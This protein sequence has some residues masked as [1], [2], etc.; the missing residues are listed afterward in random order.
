LV[1]KTDGKWQIAAHEILLNNTAVAN[2]IRENKMN[3]L[4]NVIYTYR[5]SGMTLLEDDL[6]RLVCEWKISVETA[7]FN[8]NDRQALKRELTE[9]GFL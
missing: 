5:S 7:L 1:D 3:Q 9:R 2:T 8:A 4:K 6:L